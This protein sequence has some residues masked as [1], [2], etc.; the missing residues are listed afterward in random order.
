VQTAEENNNNNNISVLS[1]YGL[2]VYIIGEYMYIENG[3]AYRHAMSDAIIILYT[4]MTV[5]RKMHI[6]TH[7]RRPTTRGTIYIWSANKSIV[8]RI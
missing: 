8:V 1:K 6:Q 5:G 3:A 2:A 4:Y 7:T